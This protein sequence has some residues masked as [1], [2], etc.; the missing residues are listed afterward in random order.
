M[1]TIMLKISSL[2][3]LSFLLVQPATSTAGKTVKATGCP[4]PS[5]FHYDIDDFGWTGGSCYYNNIKEKYLVFHGSSFTQP[6]DLEIMVEDITPFGTSS[7][8]FW[9]TVYP[10]QTPY[11]LGQDQV[12]WNDLD[13]N[14]SQD[15]GEMSYHTYSLTG[16]YN[17]GS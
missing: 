1:R 6:V 5:D 16:N 7:Y 11:Y 15:E 12:D 13:C 2:F 4:T 9:I 3:L 14:E 8:T 17:C 10:G